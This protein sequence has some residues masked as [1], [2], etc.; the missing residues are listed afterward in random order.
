MGRDAFFSTGLER[1][2]TFAVQE[3]SDIRYFGGVNVTT[4]DDLNHGNYRHTWSAERDCKDILITLQSYLVG[5]SLTVPDFSAFSADLEGTHALRLWLH[6]REKVYCEW[7]GGKKYYA[8]E[9]GCVIYH[10]LKY[11]P[12]LEAHYEP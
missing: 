11:A 10:Q 7:L 12:T 2:F 3:S 6:N 1:R 9:L 5:T 4:A 8:F